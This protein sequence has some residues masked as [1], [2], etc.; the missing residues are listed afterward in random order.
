VPDAEPERHPS[1]QDFLEWPDDGVC[2][3]GF[4]IVRRRI[5]EFSQPCRDTWRRLLPIRA[6]APGRCLAL[7]TRTAPFRRSTRAAPN[8]E[9]SRRRMI[10]SPRTSAAFSIAPACVMQPLQERSVVVRWRSDAAGRSPSTVPTTSFGRPY[11]VSSRGSRADGDALM[12]AISS[13]RRRNC[14]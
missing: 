11:R 12:S 7:S 1:R 13:R 5:V 2:G 4:Q 9:W 3:T 8:I 6:Q 14:R 10:R